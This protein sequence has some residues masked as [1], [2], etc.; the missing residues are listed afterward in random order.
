MNDRIELEGGCACGDVRYRLTRRPLIVHACH[1][2]DCRRLTGSPY[3]VNAWIE[4]KYVERLAG[5]PVQFKR[6]GGSGADHDVHFC[7]RCGTTVWSWYRRV[8]SPCWWVRVGTLD[9][10]AQLAPDVHIWTRSKHPSVVLP[11]GVPIFETRYESEQVWSADSLARLGA[12][13]GEG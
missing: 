2:T 11:D 9:D 4:Q 3:A 1:C 6:K 10:P 7:P 12:N 5:A 13:T 8:A